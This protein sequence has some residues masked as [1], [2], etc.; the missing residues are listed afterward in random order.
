MGLSRRSKDIRSRMSRILTTKAGSLSACA[1]VSILLTFIDALTNGEKRVV[2]GST[3]RSA[4]GHLRSGT[5]RLKESRRRETDRK[6]SLRTRHLVPRMMSR[7]PLAM[8]RMV[9]H[10]HTLRQMRLI[11]M[12]EMR[13]RTRLTAERTK[14]NLP[15]LSCLLCQ[16]VF[17]LTVRNHLRKA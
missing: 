10:R 16:G 12:T 14:V 5:G 7:R 6:R 15:S 13:T 8:P 3:S 11:Q 17:E 4:I 2:S 9:R 1:I